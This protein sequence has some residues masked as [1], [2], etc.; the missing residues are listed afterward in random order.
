MA[1]VTPSNV[2]TGDVLTASKW[3]QDV[4][5]NTS[6]LYTSIR[7]Y[8][9]QTRTTNYAINQTAIASAANV[10]SSSIT[11]TA[12]GTSTYWVEFYSPQVDTGNAATNAIQIELTDGGSNTLGTLAYLATPAANIMRVSVLAKVPYTPASGSKTLNVR[13]IYAGSAGTLY[14]GAGGSGTYQPCWLAVYGPAVS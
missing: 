13:A 11:F 7:Q 2:A 1:W 12:D 6:V 4:V 3:N 5:E 10:F 8:G 14:G 9:Y